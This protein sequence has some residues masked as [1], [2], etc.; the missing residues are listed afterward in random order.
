MWTGEEYMM[1]LIQILICVG[2]PRILMYMRPDLHSNGVAYPSRN[3]MQMHSSFT[4]LLGWLPQWYHMLCQ[5][6]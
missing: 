3:V 4:Y 1:V 5:L 6:P 2:L